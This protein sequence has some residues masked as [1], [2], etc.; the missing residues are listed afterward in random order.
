MKLNSGFRLDISTLLTT[1]KGKP[2]PPC[3]DNSGKKS[4]FFFHQCM[5][6][7]TSV[8]DV[9]MFACTRALRLKQHQLAK[10]TQRQ[11]S[12]LRN[13]AEDSRRQVDRAAWECIFQM[14]EGRRRRSDPAARHRPSTLVSGKVVISWC[15]HQSD[16]GDLVSAAV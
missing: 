6:V 16:P 2:G 15:S 4:A 8:C 7:F 3:G 12:Y 14:H 5:R 1:S 13:V 10:K 9:S 11:Q